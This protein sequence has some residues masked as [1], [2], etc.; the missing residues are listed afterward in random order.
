MENNEKMILTIEDLMRLLGIGRNKAYALMHSSGFPCMR[1]G[2]TYFIT[3][4]NL[5]KW[6]ENNTGKEVVL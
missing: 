4:K 6:L 2:R 1:V 5:L 3:K